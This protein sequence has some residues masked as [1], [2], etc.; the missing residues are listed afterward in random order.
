MLIEHV[1]DIVEMRRYL[2]LMQGDI[3]SSLATTLTNIER[4]GN[5]WKQPR[6]KRSAWTQGLDFEVPLIANVGEEGVDV[7]WW[8]G[9]AGAYDPRNQKVTRA[10]A[11]I[12]HAARRQL[13]HLG[14][15]G[16]LHRRRGPPRGQ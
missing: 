15:A 2:T 7:L 10:I 4:A 9:C 3:P 1:D 5:P 8:V 11:K 16:S 14:R 13:R 6:R 12:L